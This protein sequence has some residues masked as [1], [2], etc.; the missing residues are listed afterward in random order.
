MGKKGKKI[1]KNTLLDNMVSR[2]LIIVLAGEAGQGIQ[3]IESILVEVIKNG[4]FNVFATKEYMSRVRGGVNSTEIRISSSPVRSHRDRIDILI[5]LDNNSIAH[6][7]KRITSKTVVIGDSAQVKYEKLVNIPFQQIASELGNIIYSNTVAVGAICGIIGVS[8]ANLSDEIKKKFA[9]K[10]EDVIS[11]NIKAAVSGYTIGAEMKK[12]RIVQCDIKKG[13]STSGEI[14]LNG[15][16]AVALGALAGGCN[17]VFAYP[18][19]PGTAVFTALAGYSHKMEIAVEQVEDE[20]GVFNMSLG[21]WYAGG[22][23]IVSTS[24]GGFALMTEGLSLAG[25]IES[26]AVIHLAQRPGPATGLPTRTEQGDLNLALYAGH[27]FF[28]R[29]ILSPGNTIEAFNLSAMA[30]D[31]ADKYQVPVFILTDQ[32]FTDSYYNIPAINAADIKNEKFIVKTDASYKRYQLTK[33]GISPRG[34][35]GFGSGTVCADSDEHDEEG[36]I[37]EDLDGM[38]TMMADKRMKKLKLIQSAALKPVLVGDEKYKTLIVSWGSNYNTIIEAIREA[39]LKD[40]SFLHFPQVYPLSAK[41]AAYLKKAKKLILVENN[42]TG[43]LGDLIKLETGIDIQ[44]RI[45]KYNGMPFSVE[46]L[47][48][49]FKK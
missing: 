7:A 40:T 4:G 42:Q 15:S 13:N 26:P 48:K 28:P 3:S 24:G 23:A 16:E 35:P 44:K 25:A 8:T 29:I 39:G 49:S 27:G 41:T 11:K 9:S 14:L 43:Q 45:L 47:V 1:R 20:I 6:L 33:N 18:M 37:T 34:I 36:R 17:C 19:T 10:G 2:E 30:F 21:A 31:M 5:P 12:N 38:R 22:R 46:E 32:Y